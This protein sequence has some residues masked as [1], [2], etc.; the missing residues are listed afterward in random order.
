MLCLPFF[1]EIDEGKIGT[2]N[3]QFL[4]GHSIP[5]F[6]ATQ[7]LTVADV[8]IGGIVSAMRSDTTEILSCSSKKLST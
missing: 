5:T 2:T 1:L 6:T 7:T 3:P 4:T 8:Q